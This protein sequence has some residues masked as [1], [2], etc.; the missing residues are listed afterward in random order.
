MIFHAPSFHAGPE[1]DTTNLK[2]NQKNV[3]PLRGVILCDLDASNRQIK[4]AQIKI[5]QIAYHM[6]TI[7]TAISLAFSLAFPPKKP[8][9]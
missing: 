9:S 4:I 8:V 6:Y 3:K 7:I 1:S 2:K 5:A